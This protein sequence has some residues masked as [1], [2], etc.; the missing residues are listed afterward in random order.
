MGF[1]P[2]AEMNY[3]LWSFDKY[4]H[5]I[6]YTSMWVVTIY[7]KP[8]TLI[9][10]S[11]I[12]QSNNLK[13]L[14]NNTPKTNYNQPHVSALIVFSSKFE[15]DVNQCLLNSYC[16]YD[17]VR[18]TRVGTIVPNLVLSYHFVTTIVKFVTFSL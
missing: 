5:I 6:L 13:I 9:T 8:P 10:A 11:T 17:T 1:C 15:V 12:Y 7:I 18:A 3:A 4:L 2:D 16:V 14:Q